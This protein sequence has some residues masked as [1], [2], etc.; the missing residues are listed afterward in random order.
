M[1]PNKC[2]EEAYNFLHTMFCNSFLEEDSEYWRRKLFK[3][4]KSISFENKEK[5]ISYILFNNMYM[6]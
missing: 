5:Y 3:S 2:F 1:F 4:L 6:A